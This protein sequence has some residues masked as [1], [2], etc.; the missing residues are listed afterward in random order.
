MTRDYPMTCIAGTTRSSSSPNKID[1]T[2][3]HSG[4]IA[5]PL[6]LDDED[7]NDSDDENC[8]RTANAAMRGS[9][10]SASEDLPE[11]PQLDPGHASGAAAAADDSPVFLIGKYTGETY[12]SVT[13]ENP[14]YVIWVVSRANPSSGLRAYIDWVENR[15]RIDSKNNRL[16]NIANGQ[17][18]KVTAEVVRKSKTRNSKLERASKMWAARD[19]CEPRCDPETLTFAGSN[20]YIK[21][22]TCMV[23][24][25]V[26]STPR[27]E[28]TA[29]TPE[30]ICR[31]RRTDFRGSTRTTHR[32]Y[33]LDCRVYISE[34][35]QEEYKEEKKKRSH[36]SV[37]GQLGLTSGPETPV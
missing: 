3:G 20:Q 32:V 4:R 29:N 17:V 35:R 8:I 10:A 31:H 28:E 14:G 13:I 37:D 15:Y 7:D 21:K 5:R 27:E 34:C 25:T 12:E 2:K 1:E 9:A 19:P 11:T 26:T 24:G 23:C 18:L 33:C 22:S 16:I 6:K 36:I 30:V